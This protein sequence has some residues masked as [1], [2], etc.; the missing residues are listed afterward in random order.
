MRWSRSSGLF[1]GTIACLG[2]VLGVGYAQEKPKEVQ[3]QEEIQFEQDKAQSRRQTAI[4]EPLSKLS[5]E[6][7]ESQNGRE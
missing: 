1:A 3:P 5:Q 6:Q 4:G 2:L 7:G